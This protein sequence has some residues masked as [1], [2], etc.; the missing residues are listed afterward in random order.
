MRILLAVALALAVGGRALAQGSCEAAPPQPCP[1]CFA[2]FVMPD[3]QHYTKPSANTTGSGQGA[4]HFEAMTSWICAHRGAWREPRT[5]KTMPIALVL[6]LGDIVDYDSSTQWN[7]ADAAFDHLDDCDTGAVP[8]LLAA[9]NHD[10]DVQ[11]YERNSVGYFQHFNADPGFASLGPDRWASYRC[12]DPNDCQ[13]G[14][15]DWFIGGGD[16]IRAGSRNLD[17][18]GGIAGPPQDLPGRHRAGLI[19]A[20]NGQRFLFLG[21]EYEFDHPPQEL[22]GHGNDLDWPANVLTNHPGIHA[23]VFHHML[24]NPLSGSLT[25]TAMGAYHGDSRLPTTWDAIVEPTPQVL[26]TFNGH[27]TGANRQL[28]ASIPRVAGDPVIGVYRNYQG[29]EPAHG[30]VAYGGGWNDVAVFD[31]EAREIRLRSYKIGDVAL[32][33]SVLDGEIT[34]CDYPGGIGERVYP[35]SFPDTRPASLDNCPSHRNPDQVDSDGDGRGDA[36][37]N[38]PPGCGSGPELGLLL[39]TLAWLRRRRGAAR[40]LR[41]AP[42][43]PPRRGS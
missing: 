30:G 11:L 39:P 34:A 41:A 28:D 15:D 18:V 40:G 29:T 22:A 19:R 1:D 38:L 24:L 43:G 3:T 5:G 17:L 32:D 9:G 12:A 42:A 13:G 20:P 21:L 31:P 16:P 6:H 25:E 8:Y 33:G 37:E 4:G 36:C 2:V 14:P 10:L 27:F 23:I 26:M 7:R 35:Y